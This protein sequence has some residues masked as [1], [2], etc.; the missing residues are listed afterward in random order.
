MKPARVA[1][2]RISDYLDRGQVGI[3]S[4]QTGDTIKTLETDYAKY[5]VKKEADDN[6]DY[7]E[8]QIQKSATQVKPTMTVDA[9]PTSPETKKPPK[10]RRLGDGAGEEGRTPDLMLG[11]HTL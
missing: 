7:V 11:K 2:I 1:R 8:N 6:R 5:Y 3:H 10:N 4:S 9:S